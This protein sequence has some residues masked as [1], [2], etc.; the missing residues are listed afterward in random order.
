MPT[1]RSIVVE[2]IDS[3]M[4]VLRSEEGVVRAVELS[5]TTVSGLDISSDSK[6]TKTLECKH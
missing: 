3:S 4:L 1:D 6:D 2:V 5:S